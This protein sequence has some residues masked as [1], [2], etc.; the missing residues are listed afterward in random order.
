MPQTVSGAFADLAQAARRMQP[1]AAFPHGIMLHAHGPHH[2][3][4]GPINAKGQ[5][6]SYPPG[7]RGWPQRNEGA[8][9]R[10]AL[11]AAWADI[12]PQ[13]EHFVTTLR[14]HP[15][16]G[17]LGQQVWLTVA[18]SREGHADLHLHGIIAG[19]QHRKHTIHEVVHILAQAEQAQGTPLL[20][21]FVDAKGHH[22][23]QA[24]MPAR[25]LQAIAALYTNP[26]A[27]SVW[28]HATTVPPDAIGHT[29]PLLSPTTT[30]HDTPWAVTAQ[31]HG[32]IT[33]FVDAPTPLEAARRYSALYRAQ[34]AHRQLPP[35]TSH[36][37]FIGLP[38]TLDGLHLDVWAHPKT[39]A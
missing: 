17:A 2:R 37:F 14:A 18:R 22:L 31:G 7:A 25:T 33:G 5:P 35:N 26:K 19:T 15:T 16:M 23:G 38:T 28:R 20:H 10:L 24:S 39:P 12:L 30:G 6:I 13:F 29:H 4:Y 34:N 27:V 11:A 9:T 21:L 1:R 36:S 8:H 3:D 32:G